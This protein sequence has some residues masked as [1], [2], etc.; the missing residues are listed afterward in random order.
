M[1]KKYL[2][3]LA[4]CILCVGI[5]TT[6]MAETLDRG[7]RGDQVRYVQDLLVTQG[8]LVDEADGVFGNNTEYAVRVFQKEK[9]LDV[10]GRVGPATLAALEKN[11]NKFAKE[12][13]KIKKSAGAPDKYS[14]VLTMEA[15]A[16]SAYDPGN[17][18]YTARGNLLCRG[19]VSVDPD[20][21]PLGTEL[22]IEGY[23]YAVADDTGGAIRGHKIDLAVDSYDEAIQFGRRDVTVYVL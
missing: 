8:Y 5:T 23:G 6:A 18:H 3:A 11:H 9:G 12:G 14:K 2:L 15:S 21:I 16:Y 22:Y 1:L 20:V 19:L 13:K 10:D 17:S 7:K 4:L